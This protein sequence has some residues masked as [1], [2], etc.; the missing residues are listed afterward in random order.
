MSPPRS[1][2]RRG[3]RVLSAPRPA[4]VRLG[5]GMPAEVDGEPIEALRESWLV[6]DRWWAEHP[7]RRR[8]WELLGARGRNIVVFHDLATGA[9]FT[10]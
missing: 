2:E 3:G 7:L 1:Q 9:W 4:R 10:H 8:Y 6:E 5:E